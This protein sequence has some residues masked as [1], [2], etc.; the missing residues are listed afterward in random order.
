MCSRS[1][2]WMTAPTERPIL[3]AISSSGNMPSNLISD[4]VQ[5]FVLVPGFRA[6]GIFN[7]RRLKVAT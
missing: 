5:G 1:R 4:G 7:D 6:G 3:R 2:R